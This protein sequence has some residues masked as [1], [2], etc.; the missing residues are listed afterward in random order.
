MIN[1]HAADGKS[2][3]KN[4]LG[5]EIPMFLLCFLGWIILNGRLTGEIVI[6]GL[7]VSAFCFALSCSLLGW[8]REKEKALL[9]RAPQFL[10]YFLHLLGEIWQANVAVI[11]LIY[12][13]REV[14]PVYTHFTAPLRTKAA[15]IALSDSITLTPGTITGIMEDGK[16]VVHCL[17]E[18]M[19]EGLE[20]GEF[21]HRLKKIEGEETER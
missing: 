14:K 18:S 11:R 20:E 17:D 3:G 8:S 12:S 21:V 9:R 16:F 2:A 5:G 13:R 4:I 7:G 10:G 19:A 15:R 6:F 1:E